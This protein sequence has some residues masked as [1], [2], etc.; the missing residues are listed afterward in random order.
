VT[1]GVPA[2]GHLILTFVSPTLNPRLRAKWQGM[3][4][5]LAVPR[6]DGFDAHLADGPD[7][8]WDDVRV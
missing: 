6:G 8:D 3:Q 7:E 4:M 1:P 5:L 2:L